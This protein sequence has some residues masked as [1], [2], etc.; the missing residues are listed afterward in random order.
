[1]RYIKCPCGHTDGHDDQVICRHIV[2]ID[3]NGENL[4]ME[5]VRVC[6]VCYQ[7]YRVL[8]HYKFQYEEYSD[9]D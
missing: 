2:D 3:Y 5:E 7:K 6:D 4:T 1:M 9:V 8:I